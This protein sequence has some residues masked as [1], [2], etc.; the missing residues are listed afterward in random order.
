MRHRLRRLAGAG[1]GGLGLRRA[2][3]RAP[4]RAQQHARADD[5][6]HERQARHQREERHQQPTV[7]SA[8]G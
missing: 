1:G 8:A 5:E 4:A 3:L 2:A 7:I 6:G